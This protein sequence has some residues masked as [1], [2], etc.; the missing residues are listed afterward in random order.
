MFSI[1]SVYIIGILW[2]SLEMYWY[3]CV[4][5]LYKKIQWEQ[6]N[7]ITQKDLESSIDGRISQT[8]YHH[9]EIIN[10]NQLKSNK[11]YLI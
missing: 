8:P 9:I 5:L 11:I 10:K 1:T 4:W 3:Y 7:Q 2:Y 6:S